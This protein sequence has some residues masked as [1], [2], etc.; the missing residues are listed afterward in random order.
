M[1][2]PAAE[3]FLR[4]GEYLTSR[5]RW[6]TAPLGSRAV[7]YIALLND[8]IAEGMQQAFYASLPGH[9]AQARDSLDTIGHSRDLI[10]YPG[11]TQEVWS[12]RV[13]RAWDDYE[14]GGTPQVVIRNVD[15]WGRA[16]LPSVFWDTNV[17][18]TE[19]S[20]A[21][22]EVVIPFGNVTDG[23]TFAWLP[24]YTYG[25]GRVYGPAQ[26]YFTDAGVYGMDYAAADE[27][28]E[29]IAL[30]VDLLRRTVKKWKPVRSKAKVRVVLSPF[31]RYYG[32][33]NL[34]YFSP[35]Y[36]FG[37]AATREGAGNLVIPYA[38]DIEVGD[39]LIIHEGRNSV[40]DSAP[41][42]YTLVATKPASFHRTN[43]YAKIAT[44]A[45]VEEALD[46]GNLV[47]AVTGANN[48]VAKMTRVS[49]PP[50]GWN[51]AVLS[52]FANIQTFNSAGDT[53]IDAPENFEFAQ[54]MLYF[55]AADYFDVSLGA[56]TPFWTELY[57]AQGNL[58][59]YE[60]RLYGNLSPVTTTISAGSPDVSWIAFNLVYTQPIYAEGEFFDLKV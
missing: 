10:L 28:I 36:T 25:S 35:T 7:G 8:Q 20:W 15:D 21:R 11:E 42:G 58:N 52:N 23:V 45:D 29:P 3:T 9:P 43:I 37:A 34:V 59:L 44:S 16:T 48:H 12:A 39:L 54:P 13:H 50:D 17:Y 32:E 40:N 56:S 55:L 60:Y 19:S 47:Y 18:V 4:W 2:L 24:A 22:M 38:A 46:T 27:E 30:Q 51:A 14:E 57:E 31:A 33:P 6:A 1:A 26:D 5:I 41:T 53:T 49:P